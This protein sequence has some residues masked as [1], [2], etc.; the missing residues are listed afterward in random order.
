[1]NGGSLDR[2]LDPQDMAASCIEG[3]IRSC[4]NSWYEKCRPRKYLY[5]GE[6][7]GMLDNGELIVR[8]RGRGLWRFKKDTLKVIGKVSGMFMSSAAPT[9]TYGQ[10]GARGQGGGGVTC[11]ECGEILGSFGGGDWRAAWDE[12]RGYAS[13]S[14]DERENLSVRRVADAQDMDRG[15]V[16]GAALRGPNLHHKSTPYHGSRSSH[17]WPLFFRVVGF[18]ARGTRLVGKD[19]G[20]EMISEA[21]FSSQRPGFQL[22]ISRPGQVGRALVALLR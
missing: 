18:G 11:S 7:V 5:S 4:C 3:C 20:E 9:D 21:V 19:V 16:S 22:A 2:S 6:V 12:E 15:Q 17:R 14:K 13:L 8:F 1:M 10:C